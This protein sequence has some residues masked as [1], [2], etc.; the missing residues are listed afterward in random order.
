MRLRLI[1]VNATLF[2][3][4]V[5]PFRRGGSWS[6]WFG[7]HP[8]RSV[9][10]TSRI[11]SLSLFFSSLDHRPDMALVGLRLVRIPK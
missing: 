7:L 11:G 10:A 8:Q 6:N 4:R 5:K 3:G 1:Y 2:A 9:G